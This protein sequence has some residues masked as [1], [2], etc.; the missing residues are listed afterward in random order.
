MLTGA[1]GA[2]AQS[3]LRRM[4]GYMVI[5]GIGIM[6]TGVSLGSQTAVSGAIFYGLHSMLVMLALYL[7]AGV[8][9]RLGGSFSL[10]ELSGLYRRSPLFAALSLS[11]FFAV[12]GLPP[13]SGFWPKAMLVKA[14]FDYGSWWQGAA[15]LISGF[16]TTIAVARA[17]ALGW[18]RMPTSGTIEPARLKRHE[19]LPIAALALISTVFGLFPEPLLALAQSAASGILEPAAYIH[20]VFPSGVP[21]P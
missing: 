20:S 17:F 9:N 18:W 8:A 19:M 4:F 6:M 12:S 16:L 11:L 7:V 14:A 1:L 3:D 21:K 5:S 2:L 15:I 10:H 13:F